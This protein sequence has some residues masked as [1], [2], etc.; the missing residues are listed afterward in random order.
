[1]KFSFFETFFVFVRLFF[2][3]IF[4]ILKIFFGI[5]FR[6]FENISKFLHFLICFER[7]LGATR[8]WEKFLDFLNNL[9]NFR[10]RRVFLKNVFFS[11]L[12]HF[13]VIFRS[14]INVICF[15]R[16]SSL[17]WIKFFIISR[18]SRSSN[19]I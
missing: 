7:N 12:F 10:N 2:E 14:A 3:F 13:T 9:T 15:G 11:K 1:M 4:E 19:L 17:R 16:R 5:Y 6:N 18:F 8:I